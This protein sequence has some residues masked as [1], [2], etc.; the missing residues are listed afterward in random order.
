LGQFIH[1]ALDHSESAKAKYWPNPEDVFT[2]ID[3]AAN[4]GL[5]LQGLKNACSRDKAGPGHEVRSP[6]QDGS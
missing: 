4:P 3:L 6:F 2:N 1:D 5:R